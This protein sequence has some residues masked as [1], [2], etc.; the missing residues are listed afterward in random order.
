MRAGRLALVGLMAVAVGASGCAELMQLLNAETRSP[1]IHFVSA[2]LQSISLTEAVVEG[3]FQL[4]NP[5]S[6]GVNLKSVAVGVT[7]GTQKLADAETKNGLNLPAHG[8]A[9]LVVPV[10]IPFSTLPDL[11]KSVASADDMA[12]QVDGR[13]SID[14]PIGPI[15][16]PLTWKGTVP[17]PKLPKVSFGSV[18]LDHTSF[19]GARVVV[20][21]QVENPNAFDLPLSTM[22]ANLSV[23]NASVARAGIEA[24]RSL[25]SK[26]VSTIELPFELSLLEAGAAVVNAV[27]SRSAAVRLQGQASV[28]GHSMDLDVSGQMH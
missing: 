11:F 21:L 19:L 10:R 2:R 12:Y 26:Q 3:T 8:T 1:S 15:T 17:V 6:L 5:N 14:G 16:V 27:T 9:P 7:I 22:S 24:P 23:S 28:A 25:P 13:V 20:A 18:R 4:E